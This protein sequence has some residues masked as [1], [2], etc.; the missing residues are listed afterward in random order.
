MAGTNTLFFRVREIVLFGR[1]KQVI[2]VYRA[3]AD[4][5]FFLMYRIPAR[6][7]FFI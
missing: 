4:F 2:L 3:E 7:L 6:K 5:F 1:L